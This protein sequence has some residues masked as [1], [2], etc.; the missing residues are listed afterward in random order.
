MPD[1]YILKMEK[2]YI[3][4]AEVARKRGYMLHFVKE[5][6]YPISENGERISKEEL[7]GIWGNDIPSWKWYYDYFFGERDPSD[8]DLIINELIERGYRIDYTNAYELSKIDR[9]A[10]DITMFGGEVIL[11]LDDRWFAIGECTNL[12]VQRLFYST[13]LS[14]GS[15]SLICGECESLRWIEPQEI[16]VNKLWKPLFVVKNLEKLERKTYGSDGFVDN[17]CVVCIDCGKEITECDAEYCTDCSK[18]VCLNCREFCH[19]FQE[20]LCKSCGYFGF[21]NDCKDAMENRRNWRE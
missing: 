15:S 11:N 20:T 1:S 6:A 7:K 3:D 14:R 19:H 21:C 13:D 12:S 10:V 18:P 4:L 16:C 2:F 17:M 9:R 5:E 8:Y